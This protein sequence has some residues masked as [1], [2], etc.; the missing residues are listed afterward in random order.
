[1]TTPIW[2]GLAWNLCGFVVFIWYAHASRNK[3][4]KDLKFWFIV[5]LPFFGPLVWILLFVVTIV[6]SIQDRINN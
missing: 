3:P 5:G 1:M 4:Y 6:V 2:I